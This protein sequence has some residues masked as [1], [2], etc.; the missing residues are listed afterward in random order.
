ML[1][2]VK[3]FNRSSRLI[4]N[5]GTKRIICQRTFVSFANINNFYKPS[6]Q[7]LYNLTNDLKNLNDNVNTTFEDRCLQQIY[8]NVVK[9]ILKY[10]DDRFLIKV[11]QEGYS[12]LIVIDEYQVRRFLP[13]RYRYD[14]PKYMERFV[15]KYSELYEFKIST[16]EWGWPRRKVLKIEW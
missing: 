2:L 12:S 5:I 6:Q 3:Y 10:K 14:S 16:D 15:E 1:N 9:T 13:E 11:A 8:D 7:E 4:K